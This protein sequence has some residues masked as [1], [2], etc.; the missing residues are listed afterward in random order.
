MHI[1]TLLSIFSVGSE[2]YVS[3]LSFVDKDQLEP[4]CSVLLNHK[5]EKRVREFQAKRESGVESEIALYTYKDKIHETLS[6]L[7]HC[8]SHTHAHALPRFTR[9]WE[10]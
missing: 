5:V 2:H 1:F 3:I 7:V 8:L 9:W 4:G 6:L 10:F